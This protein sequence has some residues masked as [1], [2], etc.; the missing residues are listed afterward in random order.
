[1][2]DINEVDRCVVDIRAGFYRRTRSGRKGRTDL[3]RMRG[4]VAE[5]AVFHNS[6]VVH[7]TGLQEIG[8]VLKVREKRV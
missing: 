2:L 6:N 3:E 1:M 8:D 4:K 7:N 5:T